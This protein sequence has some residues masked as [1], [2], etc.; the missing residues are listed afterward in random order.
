MSNR[1][2]S[3]VVLV[4]GAGS[5]IGR[6]IAVRM[7]DEGA[8]VIAADISGAENETAALQPDSITAVHCDVAQ[9]ADIAAMFDRIAAEFGRLDTVYNNAGIT[10]PAVRAHEYDLESWDRVMD[11]NVRGAF[12]VIKH[13]IPMLLAV[14][15][16]S[17][18]NTASVASIIA[19]PGSFA[20]PPSKGAVMMMTKQAALEY[21]ADGIRVNAICPGLIRTPILDGAPVG[22]DVLATFVPMGRLGEPEEV[23]SLAAFL[24]SD[25]AGFI[26]GQG[27]FIDGGQTIG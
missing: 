23:A 21:A 14:G 3:K 19:A 27:F 18:I 25:E 17:I 2:E 26:T 8:R 16:G 13:A 5:G 1:F 4:T 24:G 20:Y 11:I 9:P 10:G 15:G 7:A 6:A 12:L 22:H